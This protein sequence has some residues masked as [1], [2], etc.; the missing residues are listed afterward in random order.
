MPF[1][2]AG[3]IR[4]PMAMLL[5][6][7]VFWGLSIP[8]MKAL[9]AEQALLVPRLGSLAS[10]LGSLAARFGS[11]GALLALAARRSPLS[12]TRYEWGHGLVLGL[13]TSASML[14]QVDGLNYT[15]ASTAGFLIAM[16]SVLV[17][18][19]AC[20]AGRR[21]W[22]AL[23]LVCCAMVL[24]GLLALTGANLRGFSL[25]RGEW[26]NLGA[27]CL[28][29]SQ[30]LWLDRL[31]PGSFDP[32]R[33]TVAL[34]VTVTCMCLLAL[35][36]HRGGLAALPRLHASPRAL[37]L[38]LF[39]AV[40]G[41]AAPFFVMN[42]FQ[43]LVDPVPAG[44]LYCFEPIASALGAMILPELLVRAPALY[45]DE[46]PSARVWLGGAL[47]FAANL[48]LLLDPHGKRAEA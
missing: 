33:L 32:S 26:E 5:A 30:I 46:A 39:L 45:P 35:T 42:R 29:A 10:S 20:A 41:T 2:R 34:C 12:I 37:W 18:L 31:K 1:R 21:P 22:S 28:F 36:F 6:A 25:G 40:A 27:A 47:I 8:I 23:L 48:L 14:A 19:F 43:P 44:F 13:I 15:S 9:G 3:R 16:Y 17:P 7:A 24:A 4:L 38:T 11:A